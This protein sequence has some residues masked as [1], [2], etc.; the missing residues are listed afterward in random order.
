MCLRIHQEGGSFC[1]WRSRRRDADGGGQDD[2][3]PQE[4]AKR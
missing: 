4:V 3:A 1:K 2:R